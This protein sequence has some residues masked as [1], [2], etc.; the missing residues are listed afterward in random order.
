MPAKKKEE[1]REEELVG[2]FL[3]RDGSTYE[4][5][6]QPRPLTEST[7]FSPS[8]LFTNFS[9]HKRSSNAGS[10]HPPVKNSGGPSSS[11]GS[12]A[13]PTNTSGAAGGAANQVD[14]AMQQVVPHGIGR[15]C[16]ASG[17]SYEGQWIE[18]RIAGSGVFQYDSGASYS[19]SLLENRYHGF[20]K[21]V[22]PNGTY[23][24]G[25]WENNVMHGLGTYVDVQGRRWYGKFF[26][27]K[28]FDLRQEIIF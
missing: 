4:G 21:Y 15:Y 10:Q 16:D 18:G 26:N 24:E 1:E 8:A 25:H 11:A 22:W 7:T 13:S 17:A 14:P 28:G 3:Y 20:G 12:G 27:G 5:R 2:L 23:Y 9:G 19:G 6:Y